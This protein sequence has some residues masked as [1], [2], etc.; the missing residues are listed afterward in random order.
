MLQYIL[1][2]N[3]QFSAGELA[4]MAIEGGCEW[5]SVAAPAMDDSELRDALVPDVVDLCRESGVFLTIDDR[6]DLA[7]ELGLHGVRLSRAFQLSNPMETPMFLRDEMGPEAV[8]G[9]ETADASVVAGLVPADIDFVTLPDIFDGSQR[10]A[11]IARLKETGVAIPVVAQGD[12]SP[13]EA[14]AAISDGCSGVAVA[15]SITE[16]PDPVA[17][18]AALVKALKG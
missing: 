5:I 14:L 16:A 10:H 7:R 15:K 3:D 17:A 4:Q 2:P 8:I 6:P 18:T 9:V 1:T 12:F 11:F 13:A